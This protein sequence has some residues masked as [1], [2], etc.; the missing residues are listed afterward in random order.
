MGSARARSTA[1]FERKRT[2][3][4]GSHTPFPAARGWRPDCRVGYVRGER[5]WHQIV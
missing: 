4:R 3:S 2:M 5:S 1:D